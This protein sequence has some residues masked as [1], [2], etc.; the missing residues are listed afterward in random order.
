MGCSD[1]SFDVGDET[2][3]LMEARNKVVELIAESAQLDGTRYSGNIGSLSISDFNIR[4][5]VME[6]KDFWAKSEDIEKYTGIV[7]KV[8]TAEH[9]IKWIG[10]AACPC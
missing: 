9:G 10:A 8:K 2:M 7:R 5:T 6:A 4:D 3:T 1:V